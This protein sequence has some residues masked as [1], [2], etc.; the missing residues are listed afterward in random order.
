M[1]V[2]IRARLHRVQLGLGRVTRLDIYIYNSIQLGHL[3]AN[4]A[5]QLA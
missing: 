5:K 2:P 1:P 4:M 3:L